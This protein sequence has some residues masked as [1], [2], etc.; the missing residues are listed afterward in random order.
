MNLQ[1]KL[2]A[3]DSLIIDMQIL[4]FRNQKLES[5]LKILKHNE[6]ISINETKQYKNQVQSTIISFDKTLEEKRQLDQM[7]IK[8]QEEIHSFKASHES[9]SN[10]IVLY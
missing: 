6:E 5:D 1:S 7:Y 2:H 10:Y 9:I 8:L 4:E 3:N